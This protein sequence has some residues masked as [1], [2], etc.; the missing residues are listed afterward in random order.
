MKTT[1]VKRIVP[2]EQLHLEPLLKL[3]RELVRKVKPLGRDMA[4]LEGKPGNRTTAKS[5]QAGNKNTGKKGERMA[6]K[7][8]PGREKKKLKKKGKPKKCGE[9]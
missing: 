9:V 5:L 4:S 2:G 8:K 1:G 3:I 6:T 7:Q